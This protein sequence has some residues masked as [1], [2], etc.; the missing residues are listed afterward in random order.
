MALRGIQ[1][2]A[3]WIGLSG[4][5]TAGCDDPPSGGDTDSATDTATSGEAPVGWFEIGFGENDFSP[6]EDGGELHVVWGS[7]GSAMFP[8]PLRGGGFSLAP[9]PSDFSDERTPAMELELD[10]EG[11][12]PASCGKFKCIRNYPIAFEVLSDGSYEFIYVRVIM[13][14][15]I[16][17]M[18]LD[19][20]AADLKVVLEPHDSPALEL[21]YSLTVRVDPPPV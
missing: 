9:D 17:P 6:V 20:R 12:E 8:M 5:L 3:V 14:D 18:T 7:Q 16:D 4:V 10:I 11:I 15:D 2:W 13:P 1:R 21:E 19:G